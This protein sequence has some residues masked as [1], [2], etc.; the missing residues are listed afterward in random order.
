MTAL[1]GRGYPYPLSSDNY[2]PASDIQALAEAV[3]A[4]V[5]SLSG[6]LPRFNGTFSATVA[7]NSNTTLTPTPVVLEGGIT[8]VGSSVTVPEAGEYEIGIVLR[9]NSQTTTVGTRVGRF[10]V[11]G[12]DRG[13]FG[14]PTSTS[15][16]ST[17][18]TSAGVSR[19][20]LA[21][22]D[23]IVFQAFHTA[24][25]ALGLIADSYAWVARV[26]Q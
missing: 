21:A 19:L 15:Q 10:N 16:N 23:V 4:D 22:G 17:N 3:D 5:D 8:V 11:N 13:F 9:W 20:V 1:T 7:N 12:T 18:I 24:G 14:Y 25:A 2:D 6:A 26:A